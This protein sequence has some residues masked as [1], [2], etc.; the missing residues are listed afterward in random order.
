MSKLALVTGA[1]SGIGKEL[2][3]IHASKKGDL[4]LV[5]RSKDKLTELKKELEEKYKVNVF[6]YALDLVKT[7]SIETLLKEVEA[8]NLQVDYLINNAGTTAIKK[9]DESSWK[10]LSAIIELNISALTKLTQAFIP[11]LKQTK[12]KILN[13]GSTASFQPI[14]NQAVYAATKAYVLSFSYA[15]AEELR[16]DKISVSILCPGPTK[17]D[18]VGENTF[19][20][21]LLNNKLITS[22]AK[23]V[24][25]IGYK[26]MLKGQME[27]IPGFGNKVGA[28]TSELLPKRITT[29]IT[30]AIFDKALK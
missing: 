29:K 30:G 1:S 11:H 5:A 22:T 23:D 4:I 15:L 12:G 2:A 10:E 9:F 28:M 20:E 7:T 19:D 27:I 26:G 17:T 14:P 24:A 16:K 18:F 13:V 3:R 25:R 21:K 8:N 6:V